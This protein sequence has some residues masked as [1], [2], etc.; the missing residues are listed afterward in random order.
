AR[1]FA[2]RVR[3]MRA[4]RAGRHHGASRLRTGAPAARGPRLC[5]RR[6]LFSRRTAQS[7]VPRESDLREPGPP[8]PVVPVPV[9]RGSIPGWQARMPG[10]RAFRRALLNVYQETLEIRAIRRANAVRRTTR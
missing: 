3:T 7:R 2:A 4:V 6:G 8:A 9:P 1:T 5:R 10:I